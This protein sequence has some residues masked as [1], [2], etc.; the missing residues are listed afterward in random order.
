ML[1]HIHEKH[2]KCETG[3]VRL[4]TYVAQADAESSCSFKLLVFQLFSFSTGTFITYE[5]NRF[6]STKKEVQGLDLKHSFF[7][8]GGS[9]SDQPDRPRRREKRSWIEATLVHLGFKAVPG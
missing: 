2:H 7:W 3:L 1:E 6:I 9:S 4:N 8:G 5:R